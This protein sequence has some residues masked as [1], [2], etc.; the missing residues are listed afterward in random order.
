VKNGLLIFLLAFAGLAAKAQF[1]Q[2]PFI[3]ESRIH[4]GMD[5]P[6][7]KALRYLTKDDIYAFD[8]SVSFP[9]YGNNYWEKLYRYPRQGI[10]FSCWSLGN[11][12]VFGKA[13][14]LYSFI[15]IPFFRHPDK[16]SF[17]YQFSF[18][19]AY[20]P[21]IFDIQKDHLNR[22]IGSHTN[23]YIHIGIDGK[24]TILPHCQLVIDAGVTHFSNGKTRSPN[25]GINAGSFS[26]GLNYIFNNKG[27]IILD[28]EIPMI[29]KRYAQSVIYSAG[30]KVYDN[31]LGK[32]Y[33]ISSVSYN[34]ERILTHK[35]K[36]GLGADLSYDGSISEALA[37]EDGTPERDFNRLIRFGLH[38]SYGV[39]YKKLV[40][41]IH[42]GHYLYYSK[43]T[44]L[45]PVYNKISVQYLF[46]RKLLGSISIKSHMAK[47]DCLE[48]GIG[49]YW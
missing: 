37:G 1:I 9:T 45:T 6:F 26:L 27:A 38:A 47:A 12:D 4:A 31:L 10:G 13:Y 33:F 32:K 24:I 11:N 2:R 34:L 19:A 44:V 42:I 39:R 28:P 49:Y 14:A 41:E 23:I 25:Y 20:L 7:Y 40:M 43:S 46:T 5:L 8:L 21:K 16:L 29:D 3:I 15:N 35:R 48:Y 17:N 36:I 22:A 18:G 30:T